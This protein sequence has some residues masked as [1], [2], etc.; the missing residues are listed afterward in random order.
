MLAAVLACGCGGGAP[1]SASASMSLSTAS[2]LS[3]S[4]VGLVELLVLDG[5]PPTCVRALS[6]PSP[7][8][9]PSWTVVAHTLFT[10]DGAAKHLAIPANRQLVFYAEAYRSGD[11]HR[12][13]VGRGCSEIRLSPG[14]SVGV[15]ITLS[16]DL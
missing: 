11:T 3:P 14:A 4:D 7:L 8:D 10:I 12:T 13:R 1:E 6:L 2:G 9:D 5:T 16:A 15:A